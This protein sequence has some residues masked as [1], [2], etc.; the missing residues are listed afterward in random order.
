[1]PQNSCP[2]LISIVVPVLNESQTGVFSQVLSSLKHLHEAKTSQVLFVDGGSDDET[3]ALC[4]EHGL[5]VV[6][7]PTN[8]RAKRI[9]EGVKRALSD[10]ILVHHPRSVIEPGAIALLIEARDHL[11]WG[12]FT[13]RFDRHHP[14]LAFTSW[15]SNHIRPALWKVL[16]LDHCLFFHRHPNLLELPEVDIFEDTLLSQNL[17]ALYG[18]PIVFPKYSTTSAIRFVKNGFLKQGLINQYMKLLFFFRAD[19]EKMNKL[20]E[21]KLNLNASY[22]KDNTKGES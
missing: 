8:S 10:F 17:Y 19:H 7:C 22:I 15:Y 4:Q 2:P 13:H 11:L 9:N 1:M 5:D 16:Y 12:G 18:P 6:V 14:F 20:Y 21:K 3:V